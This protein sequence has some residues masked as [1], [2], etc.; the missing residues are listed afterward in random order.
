MI[1]LNT[2]PSRTAD[3]EKTLVVAFN[4]PG[5]VF[6]MYVNGNLRCS[7]WNLA[8]ILDII[9]KNVEKPE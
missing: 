3:I 7:Y 8:G 5:E 6:C 2:G 4:C 9:S 1:N